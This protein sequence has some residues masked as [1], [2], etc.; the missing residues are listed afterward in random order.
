M[1]CVRS[2]GPGHIVAAH[3]G[4]V[5]VRSKGQGHVV[6]AHTGIVC[7]RSK[8]QGRVVAAHTGILCVVRSKGYSSCLGSSHMYSVC[9]QV[10]RV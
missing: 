2:K 4:I 10:Q 9:C 1:V 8:G 7:V 5:C 3:T 6:A